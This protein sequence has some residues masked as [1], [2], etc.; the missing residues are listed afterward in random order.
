MTRT[1][2]MLARLR[3]GLSPQILELI[4]DSAR[5]AGHAGAH[6]EGET[7]FRLLVVTSRFSGLSRL[8]RARLVHATLGD[9]FA[10]GLHALSMT[11]L[12]PEE[13]RKSAKE[14]SL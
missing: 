3:E 5:H 7:H 2:Q 9:S 13:Y 10:K 14:T 6:P 4:D 8:A 11:M 1:E 12:S